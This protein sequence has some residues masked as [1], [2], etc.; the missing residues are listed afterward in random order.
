MPPRDEPSHPMMQMV[1]DI[2]SIETTLT[3]V[4]P[5]V[6]EMH[7]EMVT[8]EDCK[9]HRQTMCQ[10]FD[11]KLEAA[12]ESTGVPQVPTNGWL[13]RAG[14]HA[15]S[16]TAIGALIVGVVVALVWMGRFVL[17]MEQTMTLDRAEQ[18]QANAKMLK[19]LRT[20]APDPVVVPQPI[21]VYPDAGVRRRRRPRRRVRRP[22][23]RRDR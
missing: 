4:K 21:L 16:L 2:A 18:K 17:S 8:K 15:K 1:R 11:A 14:K 23:T 12:E 22:A 5:K 7:R 20:P 19:V 9:D 6:D 3:D 10:K 13:E